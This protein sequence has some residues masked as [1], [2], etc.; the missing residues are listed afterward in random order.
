MYY[1]YTNTD[2]NGNIF[3]V[4][5]G[6]GSRGYLNHKSSE[7]EKIAD[8][9]YTTSIIKLGT[10]KEI[11]FVTSISLVGYLKLILSS[12]ISYDFR[13]GELVDWL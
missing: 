10:E 4:G 5:K 7:W 11:F 13:I 6:S 8:K 9:G 2:I 12:S 3:Y 1:L